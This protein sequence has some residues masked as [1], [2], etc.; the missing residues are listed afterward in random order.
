MN[1]RERRCGRCDDRG[2]CGSKMGATGIAWLVL[3]LV[4][5]NQVVGQGGKAGQPVHLYVAA[6]QSNMV[7]LGAWVE[8]RHRVAHP[9]VQILIRR[10]PWSK[11]E[12]EWQSV[13]AFG[14]KNKDGKHRGAGP[15]WMFSREMAEAN[16]EAEIRILMLAVSGSSLK[17]WIKGGEFY[18]ANIELIHQALEDGMELKGM[19]WHQGEAG[20]GFKHGE[21][22][23][24][25]DLF[26]QM[27]KDYKEDLGVKSLPVVAGTIG[28]SG[29]GGRVNAALSKLPERLPDFA[30]AVTTGRTLSDNVHYDAPT[31]DA[32]GEEMA[33]QML[34]LV[35][36]QPGSVRVHVR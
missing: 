7:G 11:A 26:V 29:K 17:R 22:H 6:G 33:K 1:R 12:S 13:P 36:K 23:S 9:R 16:P 3:T 15:W 8:D 4:A 32:L 2:V 14:S 18:D 19:I 34:Q 10:K 27:I 5:A 30:V 20:T 24:Y 25:E 35:G 21:G 28:K 31:C